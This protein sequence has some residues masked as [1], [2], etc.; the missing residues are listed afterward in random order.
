MADRNRQF[1][2]PLVLDAWTPFDYK[3][4]FSDLV[5]IVKKPSWARDHERRLRAYDVLEAYYRN[6]SRDWIKEEQV[7]S[8]EDNKDRREY[9]DPHILVETALTSL[10]GDRWRTVVEGA[11]ATEASAPAKKQQE[12]L[13]KWNTDEKFGLKLWENER[14]SVKL[15]DG[16]YVLGWDEQKKR[17]RLNV[18]DPGSYFPVFDE[19]AGGAEDFP[20]KVHIAYE[21]DEYDAKHDKT[22]T[23]IRRITWELIP[24][25]EDTP[26]YDTGYQDA[27]ETFYNCQYTDAIFRQDQIGENT[28]LSFF[29]GRPEYVTEPTMLNIDFIPV[30]HIPNTVA[31]QDH[32]GTSVMTHVL[33]ILDDIQS[34]DTDLQAAGATT[35]SPPIAVSGRVGN[36]S[37]QTY[38]PGT[39]FYVGEGDATLI[40]TSRS[41]D[42]LIKLKD[43]LLNRLSVNGRV[44]ESLLG[45]VKPNEVPSGI[46]LT[47]SFAP[48]TGM[49]KEMRSVRYDK[50]PIL[51]K[52]VCRFFKKA[53]MLDEIVPT[54]I[55]FGSYLPADKMEATNLVVQLLTVK[56]IS[57]ETAVQIML[58]T[59]VPI[60]DWV[61]EI[62]LI[63]ARDYE[64]ANQIALITGDVNQALEY[65]GRDPLEEEDFDELND[66]EAK[67]QEAI[68]PPQPAAS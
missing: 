36:D 12:L 44:P 64:G 14:Q 39:V 33:Q 25:G 58:E 46:T 56:A 20:N 10:I 50:Y 11:V 63:Q 30:V 32:Y 62:K 51:Y 27:A 21:F 65:L 43:A 66:R 38:G 15:G 52:F 54:K 6:S 18:Y 24:V 22:E 53:G 3:D 23:K 34:T 49:I 42:A 68:N 45:R 29:K 48:H 41:L 57:L 35:G 2:M 31:L 37:V 26:A 59:G 55:V 60:E 9:G 47:L 16:V 13:D 67:K 1:K 61:E 7:T 40:D 19:R 28:D 4:A 5:P 17:P 8:G